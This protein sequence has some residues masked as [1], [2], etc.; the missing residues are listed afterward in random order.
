VYVRTV[1]RVRTWIGYGL[2]LVN[3]KRRRVISG[4]CFVLLVVERIGDSDGALVKSRV[5]SWIDGMSVHLS[6]C[7]FLGTRGLILFTRRD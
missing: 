2:M 7:K 5:Q 1:D 3:G 4:L 6:S